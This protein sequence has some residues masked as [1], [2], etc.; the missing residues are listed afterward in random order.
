MAVN[1]YNTSVTTDNLSR[2]TLYSIYQILLF[3]IYQILL[4]R[5]YI[6]VVQKNPAT[7]GIV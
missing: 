6:Q 1:V 3:R 7:M 5:I 4:F 2:Y